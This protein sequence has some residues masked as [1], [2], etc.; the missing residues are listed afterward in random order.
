MDMR[1]SYYIVLGAL[2][3]LAM[4]EEMLFPLDVQILNKQLEISAYLD[5]EQEDS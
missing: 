5:D 4:S 2:P 3:N 1:F